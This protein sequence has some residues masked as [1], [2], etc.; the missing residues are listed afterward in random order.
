[1]KVPAQAVLKEVRSINGS[2]EILGVR[3]PVRASTV[4]GS[5]VAK[6]L[7][8]DT[9]LGTVN[10][11]V[12]AAFEQMQGVKSVSVETVNGSAEVSLP[13]NADA[14]V[15][16]HSVNGSIKADGG[17]TARR[18]W[19]VGSELHGKLGAGTAEIHVKTVNG[20]IRVSCPAETSQPLAESPS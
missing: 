13:R 6:G 1:L 12:E 4:N 3:G 8:G 17:M 10:G 16:G 7:A 15:S 18:N 14:T 5:L 20:A 9:H 11:R 19:P 2:V